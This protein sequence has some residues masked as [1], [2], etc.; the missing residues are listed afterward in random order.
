[1]LCRD[2]ISFYDLRSF[3]HISHLCERPLGHPRD[4]HESH[5]GFRW[6]AP[7]PPK[8]AP[9]TFY[10]RMRRFFARM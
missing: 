5:N 9:L 10:E 3:G 1:M 7:A 8:A 4:Y 2:W 6:D